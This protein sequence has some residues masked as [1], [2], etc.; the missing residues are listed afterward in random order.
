VEALGSALAPASLAAW[1]G[2]RDLVLF[3]QRGT[4]DSEPSLKCKEL[5]TTPPDAVVEAMRACH[6]RLVHQGVNLN[7]YT[8]E[9]NAADVHDLVR[10]LGYRQI[11]L[12]GGSYG[13]RLA[14]TALRLYPNDLRSVVLDSAFPPQAN[15]FTD[16]APA[17]QRGFDTLFQ[18]CAS[19]PTC[20]S[21][22]P[23]LQTIFA[24]VVAELDQHPVPMALTNPWT[25]RRGID[26][27]TGAGLVAELRAALYQTALVPELPLMLSQLRQHDYALASQISGQVSFGGINWGMFFS[28]E[29]GEDMEFTTQPALEA[30]VQAVA[31]ESRPFFRSYLEQSFQICQFWGTQPVPAMQKQPVVSDIPTLILA[32]AYDPTTPPSNGR[33]AAQTLARG[34]FFLFP[35]VGHG[36]HGTSQCAE[37]IL[38]AFQERPDSPPDASC[39]NT[40]GEPAFR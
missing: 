2:D 25:G 35:G 15:L 18:G 10:A 13:T 28:V 1:P 30:S 24:Q 20:N 26:R 31:P 21:K 7:A 19:S 6:D 23:N 5:T 33:L 9:Q 16:L 12:Y 11:N 40:L 29:C 27:L 39:I 8:T 34:Y 14:L 4:G 22:Y 37:S 32:G 36:I 3:D 38:H 17:A